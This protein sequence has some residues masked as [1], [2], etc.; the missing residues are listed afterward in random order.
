MEKPAIE[1]GN[2]TRKDFLPL[3]KPTIEDEE[4]N[5]VIEVLKS[6]WLT[7]GPKVKELEENI[8]RYTNSKNS[9]AFNSCTGALHSTLSAY[10]I[11]ENDEVIVPTL[12]FVAS[13]HVVTWL[14]AKPVLVD[15]EEGTFN[16]NTKKIEEKI[17]PNTK[18]I[19]PVH[20]GGHPCDMDE[21]NKIAKKHNIRVIEDAAHAIGSEYKNK[22][23]G[24]IG[25]VT[26]F[27]FYVIK[28]ITTAEGGMATTN[29]SLIADKIRK[30]AYFG[31]DKDAFDRYKDKGSWYYE[32]VSQGYKYNM[33][34]LQGA[35]GVEQLKKLDKFNEKRKQLAEHYIMKFKELDYI[36]TQEVRPYIKHSWHLFPILI[37]FNR[38][39]INRN[40]FIEAL[41]AEK[42]GTSV[43]F[44]PLHLH[45]FYQKKYGYK[46]GDFPV[47]EKIYNNLITIPLFPK[48][49]TEDVNN[50]VDAIEKVWNY[51]KKD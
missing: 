49:G 16:I 13:A 47:A 7:T 24:N 12:T 20:Y 31:V 21:I 15:S 36:K 48:M 34:S 27:S 44:I 33:D 50:V 28:N 51:Y 3:S 6:G 11:K 1:G 45:P 37:D 17:T 9:I 10:E 4:I 18:A 41:K 30:R 25:D 43:H 14:N 5:S 40:K 8:S 38:L 23:I 29:D 26:C 19:I 46:E 39:N 2:P 35:L 42:I 32:V 22:K